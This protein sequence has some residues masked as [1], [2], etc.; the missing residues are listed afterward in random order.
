MSRRAP[1]FLLALAQGSLRKIM[2]GD[3]RAQARLRAL[4]G[5]VLALDFEGL[6]CRVFARVEGGVIVLAGALEEPPHVTISG[7]AGEF[8]AS[9]RRGAAGGAFGKLEVRGD[10]ATA[11]AWQELFADLEIDW[12]EWLAGLVGDV[13][14][15]QIARAGRAFGGWL[16]GT[17]RTLEQDLSEYLRYE[18]EIVATREQLEEHYRAV[19]VL[20]GDIDRAAARLERLLRHSERAR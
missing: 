16:A 11:Q 8:I 17:G 13:V 1:P 18:I 15:H 3:E 20:T 6:D 19:T 4:E 14:A 12:E 7:T 10:A 2:A 9:R 5:R